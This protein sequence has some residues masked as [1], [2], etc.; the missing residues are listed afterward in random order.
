M[1][2]IDDTEIQ[3]KIQACLHLIAP[4]VALNT[5][6]KN[7]SLREQVDIDSLDFVRFVIRLHETFGVDIP[8][9]DYPKL[10]TLESCLDYFNAKL[11]AKPQ[12]N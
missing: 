11:R 10:L 9:A 12:Q 2:P 3:E 7:Q 8:E 6:K 1:T 4:E 5:L